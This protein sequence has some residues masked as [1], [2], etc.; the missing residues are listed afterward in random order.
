MPYQIRI[1]ESAQEAVRRIA[2]EQLGRAITNL[3]LA[4][5]NRAEA[6]HEARKSLKRLRALVRLVRGELGEQVYR[7]HN[8][9]MRDAARE[10]AGL[11]DR[12]LFARHSRNCWLG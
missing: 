2:H 11:R 4:P 6:I 12:P 8:E 7:R 1:S 5:T 3:A 9:C 10:L